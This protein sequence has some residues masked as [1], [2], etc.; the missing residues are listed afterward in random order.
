MQVTV[1]PPVGP[2]GGPLAV[3]ITD[4]P[5]NA[6]VTL[7]VEV[8]DAAGQRWISRTRYWA[9]AGTV[10]TTEQAPMEG[11]YSGVDPTGPIW[12]MSFATEGRV[13]QAFVA[14]RDQMTL[15]FTASE[16]SSSPATARAVRWWSAPGVT[17]ALVG[18]DR[19]AGAL[20]LPPGAGPHP[21]VA[22]VPGTTGAAAVESMAAVLAS[23]G[24]AAMVVAYVGEPGLPSTLVEIPLEALAAG[25]RRLADHEAVAGGGVTVLCI[26]VGTEGALAALAEI[27][28]LPVRAVI[29]IAPSS[30]IW[31]AL[32]PGLPP[33]TSSWT[34]GGQPLPYL[35][36]R[37]ERLLPQVLGNALRTR[38]LRRARSTGL[39]LYPA[40]RA[41]LDDSASVERAAIRVERIQAPLLLLSGDDD[42][43]WPASRMAAD[44]LR[45]RAAMT[46]ADEH[47]AYAGAGHFLRPPVTP[48]MVTW[49]S[50]LRSGGTPAG[51]AAAQRAA[52]SR[53][54]KFLHQHLG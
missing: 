33:S 44:L 8:T 14:P 16:P 20:Y 38:L 23:A 17:R 28:G 10:D 39:R 6:E 43:V 52:W 42:E 41:A 34:F 15:T 12:S 36:M 2:V 37:T 30:V 22:I 53:I 4:V 46:A 24:F 35:R 49:T 1:E 3:R 45:R 7:E 48:T 31:Q 32:T 21:A 25:F 47:H 27:P 5:A 51:V 29:A 19:F 50:D 54:D 26:S 9:T 40:F 13:P 11:G 18:G